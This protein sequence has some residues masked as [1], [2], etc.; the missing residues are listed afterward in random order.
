MP[1]DPWSRVEELLDRLLDGAPSLSA[2]ALGELRRTLEAEP[3]GVRRE[4]ESLLPHLAAGRV[5]PEGG[6][7]E[8]VPRLLEGLAR[9]DPMT[10]ADAP[11]PLGQGDRV[12]AWR[13]LDE[14]G[15][16]GM[17][18]VYLAERADHQFDKRVAVKLLGAAARGP[19]ARRRF[20]RERQILAGLEHPSIARLLDGGVTDDGAPFL[21]ME[22][23]EGEPIDR[24]CERTGAGLDRRLELFLEVCDAV[25]A[26]HER[27][28]AHRDLKPG[29]IL[30]TREGRPRLLDFGIAGLVEEA[31]G[32]VAATVVHAFTP[33][34]ASPEQVRLERAGTGSDVYSLGVLLYVLLA[35]RLP[36]DAAALRPAEVERMIC[37]FEPPPPSAA[38][39]AGA[40][41]GLDRRARLARRLRGD[42]DQVVAKALAKE[43]ARRYPSAGELARDLRR[44]LEGLPVE[45]RPDTTGYRAARFVSR[46]RVGV[47][48]SAAV[49]LSLVVGL[50]VAASQAA[51]A[52]RERD[53]ARGEAAKARTVSEFL[54]E[55]FEEADPF[56]AAAPDARDLLARGERKIAAELGDLPA[57]RA[58]L[59]GAMGRAYKGL[60]DY[61]AALRLSG[62]ALA[63]RRELLSGDAVGLA[64]A[65]LDHAG[66]VAS[67]GDPARATGIAGE[68]LAVLEAAGRADGEV[69]VRAHRALANYNKDAR[70]E[71]AEE[72]VRRAIELLQRSTPGESASLALLLHDLAVLRERQ[73]H[74]EEGVALKLRALAMIEPRIEPGAPVLHQMRSNLA[75]ALAHQGRFDEAEPL[76]LAALAGLE[77]RLGSGHPDLIAALT[78]YGNFLMAQGR[79]DDAAPLVERA[80]AIAAATGVKRFDA[81]GARV[82][83]ATLRREQGR[84]D[85]ALSLYGDAL[86]DFRELGV[87]EGTA[88]AARVDSHFGQ[89]LVRQGRFEE[90]LARLERA[91]AV[92]E[93]STGV[94]EAVVAESQVARGV[95]LCR[96]QAPEQGVALLESGCATL[97]RVFGPASWQ[98]ASCSLEQAACELRAGRLESAARRLATAEPA[99]TA[100][101]PASSFWRVRLG[102]VQDALGGRDQSSPAGRPDR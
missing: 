57:A 61:E 20:L 65:I 70:P 101:L 93:A 42:L 56:E 24:W 40:D 9:E 27:L 22:L 2:A 51:R 85:E 100:R 82:N 98:G 79:F 32:D 55:L 97:S 64:G 19:D 89:T 29:N 81:V 35:R 76:Y 38:V 58:D 77:E 67:A 72:H 69:A 33:E 75:I 41:D 91:V 71:I 73:G 50:A 78:S 13:L 95:A 63:V 92:Q 84:L 86:E 59:L 37:E 1:A 94:P 44:H 46:H 26:A 45:A 36:Y 8:A 34:Y 7:A 25:Q 3:E 48:A 47:A 17:G 6:L 88:A 83:L 52:A 54:T 68:G 5:L 62:E 12:G 53:V 18:V 23:V 90:G 43:V 102:Q 4:V 39:L 21:V 49:A 60:G 15:R 74:P 31:G 99:I 66:V 80:V 16:G 11:R 96:L 28:I 14:L 87:A 10:Q 30:V